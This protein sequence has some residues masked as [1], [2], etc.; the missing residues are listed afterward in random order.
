MED[1]IKLVAEKTGISTAQATM[2]VET[3]AGFIKTK[4]PV[5]LQSTIDSMLQ[6]SG[7]GDA[8]DLLGGLKDKMGGLF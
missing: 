4:L 2:A 5:G 6:G 3:V 7:S 1:L 8:G